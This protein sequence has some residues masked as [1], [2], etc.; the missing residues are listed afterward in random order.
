MLDYWQGQQKRIFERIE[1]KVPADRK[2]ISELPDVLNATFWDSE[3]RSLLQ[4]LLP[5]IQRGAEAGVALHVATIEPLGVA[6]D[7]TMPYTEA[8]DWARKYGGKLVR[9]VTRTTRDRVG[10]A[11]GNWIESGDSL[12]VLT[13]R[14]MEEDYGFSRKRATLIAQ[15]ETTAAYSRGELHAARALEKQGYFEYEKQWET[16]M[17]DIVCA[18]CKPLQYDGTNAVAGVMSN[19]DTDA[20]SI[21]GPPAHPGCRCFMN[22]VPVVPS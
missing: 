12:D 17:D 21:K 6:V 13:R 14:F 11:V 10:V 9:Q 7:W 19:F 3:I 8:A 4:V 5:F 20:G 22:T 18:I 2:S 15:T 16:V 1:P